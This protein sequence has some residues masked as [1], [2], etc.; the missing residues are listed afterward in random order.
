MCFNATSTLLGVIGDSGTV[1]IFKL[2]S[3]K[4]SFSGGSNN[5]ASSSPSG[6]SFDSRD[7]PGGGGME[8]GYEAFI[9]GKKKRSMRF[10]NV[11]FTSLSS[12]R[13]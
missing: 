4:E 9:D 3:G 11:S 7:N 1:H 13:H 2:G 6:S 5:D 8:G 10:D 12:L